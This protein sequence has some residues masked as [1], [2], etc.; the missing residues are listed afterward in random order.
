M[1]NSPVTL[2]GT[3]QQQAQLISQASRAALAAAA[4]AEG[5][6]WLGA[7]GVRIGRRM[8]LKLSKD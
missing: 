1:A 2:H 6:G 8:V 3:H 4:S 7:A 5:S